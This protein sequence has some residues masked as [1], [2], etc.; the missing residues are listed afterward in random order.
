MRNSSQIKLSALA[1][2]IGKLGLAVAIVCFLANVIIWLYR[3]S[4]P[5]C[6]IV[7]SWLVTRCLLMR[8]RSESMTGCNI[9]VVISLRTVIHMR[10]C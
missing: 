4:E 5:V 6:K 9:P 3:M 10:F 1:E 8:E 7:L 2:D